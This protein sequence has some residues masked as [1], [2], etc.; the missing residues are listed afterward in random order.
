M[1]HKNIY[2]FNYFIKNRLLKNNF[3]LC[4]HFVKSEKKV[5]NSLNLFVKNNDIIKI[6]LKNNFLKN[7]ISSIFIKHV[8]ENKLNINKGFKVYFFSNNLFIFVHLINYL[9]ENKL[10]IIPFTILS[11]NRQ[12]SINYLL[13]VYKKNANHI[14][15]NINDSFNLSEKLIQQIFMDTNAKMLNNF[16]N[17]S[18]INY[19]IVLFQLLKLIEGYSK[20]KK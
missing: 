16:I 7:L 9:K 20:L 2:M 5:N 6:K 1:K 10:P 17:F 8:Q 4:C 13:N 18:W 11:K 14:L 15:N 3:I 19:K 12:I